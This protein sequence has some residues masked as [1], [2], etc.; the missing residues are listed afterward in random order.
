VV[1]VTILGSPTAR[2]VWRRSGAR[3]GDAA[4]VTGAL[5]GSI[6]GRHLDF[7]PRVAEALQLAER[8]DIHAAADISD[9]LLIDLWRMTQASGCGAEIELSRVPISPDAHE[10]ARR[11]GDGLSP[12]EHA[13]SDGEDF[14]LLMAA[15]PHE[16]ARLLAEQPL[17]APISQVGVFV[18]SPGLWR[19][20]DDGSREP[21]APRGYE[22]R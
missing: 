8:Y 14:E 6:L 16:A 11:R 7:E 9:G 18:N 19:R 15:S 5:G 10:L 21:L 3:P 1:S 13:L 12:L 2:G 4:L 20:S 17:G 22:H